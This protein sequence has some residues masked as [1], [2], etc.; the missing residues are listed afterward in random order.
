MSS[1]GLDTITLGAGCFWCVE[2]I[3]LQ[4]N[5]VLD[6]IPGYTGGVTKNPTYED[7]CSGKTG[8]DV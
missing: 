1:T 4:L 2:A 5:G 8:T 6:V 7:I 3:F